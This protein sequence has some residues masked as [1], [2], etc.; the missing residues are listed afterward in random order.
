MVAPVAAVALVPPVW[1]CG[2]GWWRWPGAGAA[3]GGPCPDRRAGRGLTPGQRQL[4]GRGDAEGAAGEA[5]AAAG[6]QTARCGAG[7]QTARCGDGEGA[8][9]AAGDIPVGCGESV[10]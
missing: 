3:H 6:E 10:V 9:I 8:A 2:C 7:E 1:S 5:G 4:L